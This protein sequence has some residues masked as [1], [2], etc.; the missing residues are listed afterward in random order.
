[1]TFLRFHVVLL[2]L[3]VCPAV[4]HGQRGGSD[5]P[6]EVGTVRLSNGLL[7]KGLCSTAQTLDPEGNG[8]RLELRVVDEVFRISFVSTRRADPA[9]AGPNDFPNQ[10]FRI[11][12][13]RESA[14]P[15]PQIL[16]VGGFGPLQPDGTQQVR[17]PL[18]GGDVLS[19]RTGV[20]A[21]SSV[22]ARIN[23]LTHDWEYAAPLSV[24]PDETLLSLIRKTPEYKD[25]FGR[26]ALIRMLISANR[27][28]PAVQV[29]AELPRDFPDA[30][31][32]VDD[33]Q[34]QLYQ[35]QGRQ[36]LRE[37]Q[38][39]AETGRHQLAVTAARLFPTENL[40]PETLVAAEQLIGRY[41]ESARRRE[42][43]LARIQILTARLPSN[44]AADYVEAALH[45]L[46]AELDENS[47]DNLAAFEL[48][49]EADGLDA[50]TGVALALSGW[51]LG[52]EGALQTLAEA[53]GL[54]QARGLIAEY[55]R[56]SES[57]SAERSS[58]AQQ[59]EK[60]EGVSPERLQ[61]LIRQMPPVAPPVIRST[62]LTQPSL[63]E[64]ERGLE[65]LLAVPPEYAPTRNWPV[66]IAFPQEG[67][68]AEQTR[69]WWMN[70]TVSEGYLLVVPQLYSAEVGEWRGTADQHRSVKELLRELKHGFR[71][72]DNR[73]FVAGHGIGGEA[74]MDLAASSPHS[75][76]GVISLAGLGRRHLVDS[77][78][79]DTDLAWYLVMGDRQAGWY[80]RTAG[81]LDKL[82]LRDRTTRRFA[83]VL[84]TLYPGRGF[85]SFGE[86]LPRVFEWMARQE[87][88]PWPELISAG[89][90][91]SSDTDWGWL[92][93]NEVPQRF[94][95]LDRGTTWDRVV[96]APLPVSARIASGNSI[97]VEALP[98]DGALSIGPDTPGLDLEKPIT[99]RAG[100]QTRRV[101]YKPEIADMLAEYA[102]TGDR[103]RLCHMRIPVRR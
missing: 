95:V 6:A 7:L 39:L 2:G 80:R 88:D 33:I 83:D 48:L 102:R 79:N 50:E 13:R 23:G 41:E 86:E 21:I 78:Y 3:A 71:L 101:L 18:A 30:D 43:L 89:A 27:L 24:I 74:A 32:P 44:S 58:I 31:L 53:E 47:L 28:G 15:M 56:L 93:L 69:N 5:P 100:R 87:R 29:A 67:V 8:R 25:A 81:M 70:R 59:I 76:A 4:V 11:P 90:R 85:E 103:V 94:C 37:L 68:T 45:D 26:A 38:Q 54:Y 40:P 42:S 17:F 49:S 61:W 14:Y 20:T 84:L 22:Y 57:A 91:R 60:L 52:S 77:V 16:G 34:Q 62:E 99:V 72:D 82:F 19:A 64:W 96:P 65:A 97:L 51:L 10:E 66:L 46:E 12:Q 36:I 55:C 92:R 98:G 35:Q 73:V 75:F 9:V 63:L 1:M